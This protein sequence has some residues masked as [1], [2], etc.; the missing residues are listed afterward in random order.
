ML[1]PEKTGNPEARRGGRVAESVVGDGGQ[2]Q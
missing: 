1:F 2:R